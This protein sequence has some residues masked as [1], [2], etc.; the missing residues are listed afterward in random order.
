MHWLLAVQYGMRQLTRCHE[1]ALRWGLGGSSMSGP[2][3]GPSR[4]GF[5]A[6]VRKVT[7]V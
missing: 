2:G 7:T 6:W 5:G 4:D 1:D 3:T